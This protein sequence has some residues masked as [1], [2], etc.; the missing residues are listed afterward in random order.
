MNTY[1]TYY[2]RNK[3][4]INE[5]RE[6]KK[7]SSYVSELDQKVHDAKTELANQITEATGDIVSPTTVDFLI[8][9]ASIAGIGQ[10]GDVSRN[11]LQMKAD[12]V[13]WKSFMLFLRNMEAFNDRRTQNQIDAYIS[14]YLVKQPVISQLVAKGLDLTPENIAAVKAETARATRVRNASSP[15]RTV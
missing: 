10:R 13:L 3:N 1:Q 14:K 5:R 2:L 11:V 8:S 4:L 6:L 7:F 15:I 12:P 9:E